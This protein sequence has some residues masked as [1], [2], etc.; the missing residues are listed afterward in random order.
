MKIVCIFVHMEID[1]LLSVYPCGT[2]VILLATEYVGFI[3]KI[4]IEETSVKYLVSYSEAGQHREFYFS[5]FELAPYE[6]T[7]DKKHI[8]FIKNN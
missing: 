3:T 4:I 6:G 2:R 5:P 7:Q 8:G 1:Y